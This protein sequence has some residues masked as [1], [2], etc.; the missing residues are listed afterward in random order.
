MVLK[1]G[2]DRKDIEKQLVGLI[3]KNIGPVAFFHT[4]LVID[5]LPKTRS[6]KILRNVLRKII[7]GEPYK[8]PATIEDDSV[9]K[10]VEKVVKDYGKGL[11]RRSSLE[12]RGDVDKLDREFSNEENEIDDP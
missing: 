8:F 7:E 4:V 2:A 3:R 5:R 11:G 9:L 10:V 12:Y 6:G 1:T